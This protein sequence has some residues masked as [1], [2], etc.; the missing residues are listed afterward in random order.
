MTGWTQI[1]LQMTQLF[2]NGP[3]MMIWPSELG[4]GN[5]KGIEFS[6]QGRILLADVSYQSPYNLPH[7]I[8]KIPSRNKARNVALWISEAQ[9]VIPPTASFIH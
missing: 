1:M 3:L 4:R 9:I 7:R 2:R 5:S 8:D 6:A